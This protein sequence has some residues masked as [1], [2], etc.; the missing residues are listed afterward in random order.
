MSEI[1][2]FGTSNHELRVAPFSHVSWF[3][4]HALWRW[5][6]VQHPDTGKRG[7]VALWIPDD[8]GKHH[9]VVR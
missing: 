9:G 3:T 5:R 8:D 2:G 7:P 1:R 4:R 6:L